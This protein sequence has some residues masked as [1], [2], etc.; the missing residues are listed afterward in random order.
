MKGRTLGRQVE[1]EKPSAGR[2]Q[3]QHSPGPSSLS[4]SPTAPTPQK[5][6]DEPYHLSG[7]QAR[8][9]CGP[10]WDMRLTQE[11]TDTR[12]PV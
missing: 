1:K 3:G 8:T 6:E 4:S 2:R 9:I 7:S 5:A 10:S 11:L 12:S